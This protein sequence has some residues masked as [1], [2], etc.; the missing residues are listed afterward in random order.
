MHGVGTPVN[1]PERIMTGPGDRLPPDPKG[2]V[3]DDDDEEDER[4]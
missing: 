4:R 2:P 3:R 1:T